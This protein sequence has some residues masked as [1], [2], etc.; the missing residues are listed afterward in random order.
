MRI[1]LSLAIYPLGLGLGLALAAPGMAAH[2]QQPPPQNPPKQEQP[3]A[4]PAQAPAPAAAPDDAANTFTQPDEAKRAEAY[5][6]FTMGHLS[7][8]QYE[9]SGKAEFA[10]DAID[11][12]KKALALDPGSPAIIERLAETYAKSQRIRDAVLEAENALKAD[13]DNLA[14]HRLLARIYVRTLGDQD[15][16]ANQKETIRRAVDQLQ[17]VLRIDPVDTESALWLARLYR[18]ENE[19]SKAEEV[20]RGVL[21]RD[22]GNAPA[23]EQLSQLLLDEGRASDA[24][25]LLE[26]SAANSGNPGLSD[27]LA[28]AYSQTKD[29]A[30]AE[31]AYRQAVEAEPDEPS[32]RRGLAQTLMSES[33][34]SDALEQYKKLTTIEPDIPENYLRMAQ[35]YRRMDKLDLAEN[36]L[37]EAKQRSPGNLE[38]LYNEA[39]LYESQGRYE[40]AIHV[41][42]DAIAGVKAA[43][44]ETANGPNTLGILYEQLGRIYRDQENYPAAIKTFE[45]LLKMGPEDQK[46]GRMLLIDTYRASHDIDR[47]IAETQKAMQLDPKDQ[48]LVVT[49]AMLLGE[50]GQT[51]EGAKVLRGMLRGNNSDRETYLN[52][53]QVEERGRRYA[54]AERAATTAEQMSEKPAEKETAWFMLGAIYERQKKFDQAE[55]EFRKVLQVNPRNAAVLNYYGYM[56]ADRGIRLEEAT[57]L[58]KR[59]V[60]EDATNGAYLDSLGWA[61][62]KQNKLAEAE[63]YLRKAVERTGH[64]PTIMEHLGDVYYKMGRPERAAALWEKSLVEWQKALP[65]DY[66]ADRVNDLDKKLKSVKQRLAQKSGTG[67]SKPQ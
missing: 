20:L 2:K 42:T 34:Y 22:A 24:I 10:N 5:Y 44:P 27:L 53:A 35:I 30:K 56:L 37:L 38:V 23:L 54:E 64:D 63:E 33:R 59:A 66:E 55:E 3:A 25:E 48:D 46:R 11:Y 65:A 50:K 45:E 16:S 43:Q 28:D 47:A 62:Y 32:H 17:A 52:L 60:A 1:A 49:Y 51:E 12:Y 15:P 29:Y 57:T 4:K 8:E 21:R 58:I 40:D 19:H 13:P 41:L 26:Q 36:A 18:F 61:Y 14:A 31:Q 7:E 67:E 6:N 39:V 9:L